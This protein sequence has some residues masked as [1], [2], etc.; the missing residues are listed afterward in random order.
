VS[1]GE[2]AKVG[3]EKRAEGISHSREEADPF[4]TEGRDKTGSSLP[5]ESEARSRKESGLS[6]KG[7]GVDTSGQ[8]VP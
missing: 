2:E 1:F 6:G 8:E 3:R 4:M 5:T 7:P